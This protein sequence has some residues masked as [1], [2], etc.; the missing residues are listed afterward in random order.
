[1]TVL[2]EFKQRLKDFTENM[3]AMFCLCLSLSWLLCI[4]LDQR[5]DRI[6][7]PLTSPL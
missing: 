2:L 4:F 1:M 6:S 3:R 7:D 5:S